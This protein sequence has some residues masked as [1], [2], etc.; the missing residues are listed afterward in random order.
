MNTQHLS[1]ADLETFD[2]RSPNRGKERRFACPVCGRNKPID[3]PHRSLA[4]NTENGSFFAIVAKQKDGCANF[5][6]KRV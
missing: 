3:A 4:V 2:S 1:M 5:G 6:T